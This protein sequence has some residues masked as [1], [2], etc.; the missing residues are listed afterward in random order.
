[1]ASEPSKED[2]SKDD[3]LK[4]DSS[5]ED[6]DELLKLPMDGKEMRRLIRKHPK[7]WAKIKDRDVRLMKLF[8]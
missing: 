2:P 1:M 5:K 6:A 8:A 3:P 7:E 4:E